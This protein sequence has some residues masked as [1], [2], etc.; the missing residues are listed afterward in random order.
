MARERPHGIF[1]GEAGRRK[2]GK[3]ARRGPQRTAAEHRECALRAGPGR[4]VSPAF[5]ERPSVP[6][7][8]HRL[9]RR[10]R[11]RAPGRREE[12]FPALLRAQ[13][14]EPGHCRRHRSR[15][16][17][18]NLWRN[19]LARY[20]RESRSRV[21]RLRSPQ[22]RPKSAR[23]WETR[24]NCPASTWHGSRTRYFRRTTPNAT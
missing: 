18:G 9:A 19:T 12:F 21:R 16:R 8:H 23:L 11:S 14:R 2:T 1:A 3:S 24:W 15:Q 20:L 13:Q 4:A 7:F 10:Y 22:S 17:P 6:R 5:P